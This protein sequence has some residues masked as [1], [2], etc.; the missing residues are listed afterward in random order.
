[1]VRKLT[2]NELKKKLNDWAGTENI[3]YLCDES[4]LSACF[5]WLV[6]KVTANDDYTLQ[7]AQSKYHTTVH[8]TPHYEGTPNFRY[9]G[10]DGQKP[11]LALCLAIEKLI[12][13]G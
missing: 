2:L 10:E 3:D 11:A 13:G 4:G 6:P 9:Y 5:K 12:D 7:V 1:M 8:I